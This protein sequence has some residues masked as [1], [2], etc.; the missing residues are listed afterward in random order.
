MTKGASLIAIALVA[1]SSESPKPAGFEG[2]F[3]DG[4]GGSTKDGAAVD[5]GK[6]SDTCG[7]DPAYLGRCSQTCAE[8]IWCFIPCPNG[9]CR[10]V[11]RASSSCEIDCGGAGGCHLTCEEGASCTLNCASNNCTCTGTG[12]RE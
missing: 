5:A 12:C 7:R 11:C 1:C 2:V 8:N 3:S 10:D 6:W 4:G 9:D